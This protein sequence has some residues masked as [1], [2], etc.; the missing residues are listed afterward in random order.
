MSAADGA[1]RRASLWL[2]ALLAGFLA[3]CG[4]SPTPA[5]AT[6]TAAIPQATPTQ[7]TPTPTAT[8]PSPTATPT[9]APTP[10]ATPVGQLTISSVG[11]NV[12]LDG[13]CGDQLTY[14]PVG[15][16]VCYWDLTAGGGGFYSFAG[17][18]TGPLSALSRTAAGA[19]VTWS[20]AGKSYTR[21]VSGKSQTF[22]LDTGHGVP[23]GQPAYLQMRTATTVVEYDAET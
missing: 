22:P 8:S 20:V 13:A 9:P 5:G 6:P 7:S 19:I 2:A 15:S 17:T 23:P 16:Q 3:S 4:A 10:T 12:P 14:V 11:I 1:F 21:K 18:T